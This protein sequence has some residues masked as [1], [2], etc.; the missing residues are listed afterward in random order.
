VSAIVNA[1]VLICNDGGV[2]T[3]PLG[4]INIGQISLDLERS[5]ANIDCDK[6]QIK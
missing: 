4:T 3:A 2:P 1:T 5:R 6:R